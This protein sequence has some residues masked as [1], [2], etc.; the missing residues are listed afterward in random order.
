MNRDNLRPIFKRAP[1][2][3]LITLVLFV[4]LPVHWAVGTVTGLRDGFRAFQSELRECWR[5]GRKRLD[6]SRCG[7]GFGRIEADTKTA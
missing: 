1:R 5:V 4:G 2:A 7:R 3:M 6:E